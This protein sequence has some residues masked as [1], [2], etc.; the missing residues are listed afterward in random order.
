M[1]KTKRQPGVILNKVPAKRERK[2]SESSESESESDLLSRIFGKPEKLSE[3][4]T[5]KDIDKPLVN[6][7][8]TNNSEELDEKPKKSEFVW[9]DDDDDTNKQQSAREKFAELSGGWLKL[10]KVEAEEDP[11]GGKIFQDDTRILPEKEIDIEECGT[12]G[13]RGGGKIG[14][15]EFHP[16]APAAMVAQ[17]DMLT[18]FQVRTDLFV[19]YS[20][21]LYVFIILLLKM[22][23][24]DRRSPKS[25][26]TVYPLGQISNK[27][28]KDYFKARYPGHF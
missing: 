26:I 9:Q 21:I 8:D 10:K 13:I 27:M 1:I 24:S 11:F 28:C 18:M 16:A 6:L 23:A 5:L 4:A 19:E 15:F 2:E 12:I 3:Q 22:I 20:N 7:D 14:A 25:Q 17:Q